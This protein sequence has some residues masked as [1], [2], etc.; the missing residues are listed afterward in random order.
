MR[1]KRGLTASTGDLRDGSYAGRTGLEGILLVPLI[2][3]LDERSS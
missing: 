2:G 3:T 1:M